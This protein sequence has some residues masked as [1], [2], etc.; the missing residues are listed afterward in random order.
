MLILGIDTCGTTAACALCSETEVI[1]ECSF[2]T[3]HTHSQVI[4]PLAQ[5][6][7]S[8]AEKTLKDVDIFA[9]V[10]GPGSYT[11]LRIGIS[12]VQGMCYALDRKCV[13]VSALEALAYNA[14][15]ADS[16]ICA[17]MHARQR[18]MYAAFF[19]A[20]GMTVK[21]LTPDEIAD[22]DELA[23][24][25]AA[26]GEKVICVGDHAMLALPDNAMPAPASQNGRSAVSLCF[27]GL[28][29]EPCSPELLLPDYLQVTKAEKDLDSAKT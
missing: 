8:D 4:L 7:L 19:R 20:D 6:V 5:K 14:V 1:S 27:A 10:S 12:A 25:I 22:A 26:C 16:V 23:A 11:G 28:A 21:R 2:L 3:E 24:R 18:L 17:V 29:H 13:G 9:A 15:C